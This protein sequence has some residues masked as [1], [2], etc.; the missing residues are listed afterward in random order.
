M[1]RVSVI[2]RPCS[3]LGYGVEG[4]PSNVKQYVVTCMGKI[5]PGRRDLSVGVSTLTRIPE[6]TR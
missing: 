1:L 2:T 5:N 3:G 4:S 6:R